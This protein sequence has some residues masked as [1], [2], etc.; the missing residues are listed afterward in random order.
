M[1]SLTPSLLF[2]QSGEGTDTTIPEVLRR[3]MIGESPR[4]PSDRVIGELGQGSAPYAAFQY[5]NTMMSALVSGVLDSFRASDKE[6]LERC[7]ASLVP[8]DPS[9]F[10]IGG[11]RTEEDGTVS[12]LVRF[13]G[14]DKWIAGELYLLNRDDAWYLD[15]LVLEEAQ[16]LVEGKDAYPYDFSPYERF[17]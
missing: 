8:V 13:L 9:R 15:D 12:F 11:G 16:D 14:R 17:F 5:A 10:H 1:P 2:S 6:I 3:P 4:Y 7:Q